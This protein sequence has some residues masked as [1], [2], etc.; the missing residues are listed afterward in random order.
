VGTTGHQLGAGCPDDF[1]QSAAHLEVSF[2]QD[3]YRSAVSAADITSSRSSA[4][5]RSSVSWKRS[6]PQPTSPSSGLNHLDSIQRRTVVH[7]AAPQRRALEYHQS[8]TSIQARRLDLSDQRR[9]CTNHICHTSQ[10]QS[11]GR[12]D[13][14]NFQTPRRPQ[15]GTQIA[16][17]CSRAWPSSVSVEVTYTQGGVDEG[18]RCCAEGNL[19]QPAIISRIFWNWDQMMKYHVAGSTVALCISLSPVKAFP[20]HRPLA[21]VAGPAL[22]RQHGSTTSTLATQCGG[23]SRGLFRRPSMCCRSV[24]S[25]CKAT[26]GHMSMSKAARGERPGNHFG[27]RRSSGAARCEHWFTTC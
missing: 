18:R 9:R 8:A 16:L 21:R 24:A 1:V 12:T 2:T 27:R 17:H 19:P 25:Q 3:E 10:S 22:V 15:Q 14:H 26:S 23:L 6:G 20:L 4:S 5:M 11:A 7:G 13:Q